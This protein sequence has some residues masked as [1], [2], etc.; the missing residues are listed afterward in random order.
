MWVGIRGTS[1]QS[2]RSKTFPTTQQTQFQAIQPNAYVLYFK[3]TFT[4]D[5]GLHV[6]SNALKAR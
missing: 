4:G 1:F 5:I 2:V 3:H 6:H